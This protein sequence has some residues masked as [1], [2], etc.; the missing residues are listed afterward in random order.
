MFAS[1]IGLFLSN[2]ELSILL[3]QKMT[4][5]AIGFAKKIVNFFNNILSHEIYCLFIYT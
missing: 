3:Y 5:F 1:N 4:E 2:N